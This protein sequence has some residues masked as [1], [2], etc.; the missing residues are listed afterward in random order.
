M[1]INEDNLSK[2][3]SDRMK[4]DSHNK[5]TIRVEVDKLVYIPG[6]SKKIEGIYLDVDTPIYKN[7]DF[8]TIETSSEAGTVTTKESI[9]FPLQGYTFNGLK[10]S[11]LIT[12]Y[13][14]TYYKNTP[15]ASAHDKRHLGMDFAVPKGTPVLACWDGEVYKTQLGYNGGY[16]NRIILRHNNGMYSEY[17][18]L[19]TIEQ[20]YIGKIGKKVIAGTTIGTVGNT[21]RVTTLQGVIVDPKKAAVSNSGVH[22]H[23]G[24]MKNPFDNKKEEDQGRVD[25]EPYLNG[26]VKPYGSSYNTGSGALSNGAVSGYSYNNVLMDFYANYVFSSESGVKETPFYEEFYNGIFNKNPKKYVF[27]DSVK[28]V[29]LCMYAP[30]LTKDSRGY[31]GVVTFSLTLQED[32][33]MD[34]GFITNF[35]AMVNNQVKERGLFEIYI[36]DKLVRKLKETHEPTEHVEWKDIPVKA[37]QNRFT[38]KFGY[39]VFFSQKERPFIGFTDLKIIPLNQTENKQFYQDIN[40]NLVPYMFMGNMQT[41]DSH[42]FNTPPTKYDLKLGDFTYQET[43]VLDNIISVDVSSSFDQESTTANIVITNEKGHYSPDYNPYYFPENNF[44]SPFS[45]VVGGKVIGVLSENTPIRIYMGYGTEVERV[46]TGLIDKVDVNSNGTMTIS[47]RDMYKLLQNKVLTE[48]KPNIEDSQMKDLLVN[49]NIKWLKSALV[50]DFIEHAGMYGWRKNYD[51]SFYPDAIIEETYYI[52]ANQKT[53]KVIR[54]IPNEPGEFEAVDIEAIKTPTGYLNP[55]VENRTIKF[56]SYEHKVS[57]IISY[58]ID[59]TNYKAYCDRYGTFR[60]ESINLFTPVKW[61]YTQNENLVSINKTIDLTKA[62]SHLVIFQNRTKG[63]KSSYKNFTDSDLYVDL[64]G[65]LRTGTMLVEWAETDAMKRIVAERAFFDMKRICR[66][67]QVTV[68]AN[69]LLEILDRIYVF[70]KQTAT[71][72][73]YIIK[74]I[75]NTFNASGGY[76]QVLDLMWADENG[77]VL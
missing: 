3:L 9:V 5:P 22:L 34:L 6:V 62:R 57:D 53:S 66:T 47:A 40:G 12:T 20:D 37:G 73:V 19:D 30:Q 56:E 13:Y 8:T 61:F 16:G 24:I 25:P 41:S 39:E 68:V 2:I 15:N 71:R 55:F 10:T 4:L 43:L 77:A 26:N 44:V 58:L 23:F 72:S 65:E 46:F 17:F 59:D 29:A 70:D 52:E 38:F 48:R 45:Y 69:P 67:L 33:H 51:D 54:A 11:K 42:I 1:S 28:K 32:A 35:K 64:K 31:N 63:Q 74:A 18:H 75:K 21:G 49:Q 50:H 60:L 27:I 7:I 76:L 14:K 36:N